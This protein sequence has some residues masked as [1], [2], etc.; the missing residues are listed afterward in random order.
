LRDGMPIRQARPIKAFTTEE[1]ESLSHVVVHCPLEGHNEH[2]HIC[3][4]TVNAG[5]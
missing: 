1:V 5:I 2:E 4:P 3:L